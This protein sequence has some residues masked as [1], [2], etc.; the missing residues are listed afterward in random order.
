MTNPGRGEFTAESPAVAALARRGFTASFV[1]DGDGLR[2]AETGRRYRPEE[3]DIR[4]TYR[5]EGT[6][7]P[8]DMSIVYALETRD[9]VRGTLVDAYGVNADPAVGA[10]LDRMRMRRSSDRR[11]IRVSR[12]VLALGALGLAVLTVAGVHVVGRRRR[13]IKSAR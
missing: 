5:F 1:V 13:S 7:D 8:D 11:P 9:G 4:D 2:A 10:L 3:V 12:L 6:S